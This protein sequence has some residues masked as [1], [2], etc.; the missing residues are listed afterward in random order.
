M[1]VA[2]DRG[3]LA[4]VLVTAG[5]IGALAVAFIAQYGFGLEP[6]TVCYWQRAPYAMTALLGLLALMPAVGQRERRVVLMHLAL[7][8][9]IDA[10]LAMYHVGVEQH[11][12]AGPGFCTGGVGSISINDLSAALNKAAHPSC[13]APAFTLGGISIAG[14]NFIA[15]LAL[16]ALATLATFKRDWWRRG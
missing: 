4:T 3:L 12:W 16:T 8:L 1:A 13:D 11:W 2:Q 5:A 10:G 7:L 9:A 14:F 15:A 6:C